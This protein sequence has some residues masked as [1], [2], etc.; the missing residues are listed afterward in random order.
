MAHLRAL[1]DV[2]GGLRSV[3]SSIC[4]HLQGCALVVPANFINRCS[5]KPPTFGA[6]G[7]SRRA[8]DLCD[9]GRVIAI[10]FLRSS[11]CPTR[12]R[13]ARCAR[14]ELDTAGGVAL[15]M[16]LDVAKAQLD[17]AEQQQRAHRASPPLAAPDLCAGIA[18]AALSG[19]QITT[20]RARNLLRP[21][22]QE[23]AI[24]GDC[25]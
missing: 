5:Q 13:R 9:E 25:A 18:S 1:R 2:A 23:R 10:H 20:N 8:R 24:C 16:K 17:G 3:C 12:G 4:V 7:R 6:S 11:P 22:R 19:A 14:A 15:L 21:I